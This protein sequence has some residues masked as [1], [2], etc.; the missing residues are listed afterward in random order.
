MTDLAEMVDVTL[1]KGG[2]R[3]PYKKELVTDGNEF[4]RRSPRM[5]ATPSA[6]VNAEL[7]AERCQPSL[8]EECQSMPITA[9]KDWNQKGL[10]SRRSNSSR[11]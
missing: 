1:P 7:V 3:G 2:P 8:P 10:A 5:V 4:L 6:D 11:P 9:P